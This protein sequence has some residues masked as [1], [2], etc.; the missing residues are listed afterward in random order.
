VGDTIPGEFIVMFDKTMA[1]SNIEAQ[2]RDIAASTGGSVLYVY[3]AVK[4][5]GIKLPEKASGE[6]LR[7]IPGVALVEPNR[8]VSVASIES[9]APW[10]LDRIDQRSRPINGQYRYSS[11]GSGVT[12]YIID[13]GIRI[14]HTDFGNRASVGYDAL[15]GN[16][17][18]CFGHGTHVAG[19]AGGATYGV[20]KGANLV[21]VRVF[22]CGGNG[23]LMS[24]IAGVNW[25]SANHTNPAVAN[26]SLRVYPADAGLDGVVQNLIAN[27]V[28]VVVAAGNDAL[29]LDPNACD[30]S[31]ARVTGAI[32][33]AATT[34]ADARAA[35]S[36]Y[37]TCVDLFAPGVDI[38][39]DGIGSNTD[40]E[41]M[42]G[43]S[44]ATAFTSG[45]VA[46]LRQRHPG[47]APARLADS[48]TSEA[49]SGVVTN[50]GTGS[51][52]RLLFSSPPP[53]FAVGISGPGFLTAGGTYTWTAPTSHGVAPIHYD[54][55]VSYP[56]FGSGYAP[57]GPDAASASL[58]VF[59][60][61]GDLNLRVTAHSADGQTAIGTK[62]VTNSAGCFPQII[63]E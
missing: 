16:G 9:N 7:H 10:G 54:W 36:D 20:A 34:S 38:L 59:P 63:C 5:F 62:H 2:S 14:T 21:A 29:V 15:S 31:P 23:T 60:G 42:S 25:V 39:S 17:I 45:V 44:M 24:V 13:S 1:K 33:V 37:G 55:E 12:I 4:G 47:D 61:D 11:D 6:A 49:T 43:T 30:L 46:L 50:T 35:F 19:I 32:T 41:I 22:D 3:Q 52:N 28:S 56:D 18:D 48:V 40:T 57:F 27:G 26:M 51:P 53:P 58:Q 8:V